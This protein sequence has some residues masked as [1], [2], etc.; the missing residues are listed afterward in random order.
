MLRAPDL[1]ERKSLLSERAEKERSEHHHGNEQNT[2]IIINRGH[3]VFQS[4]GLYPPFDPN[5]RDTVVV[6]S[7]QL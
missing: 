1:A 2:D 4:C 6:A 7:D 5:S 3:E